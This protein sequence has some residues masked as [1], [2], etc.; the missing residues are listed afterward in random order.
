MMPVSPAVFRLGPS[1][2]SLNTESEHVACAR[3][4]LTHPGKRKRNIVCEM[5]VGTWA[6]EELTGAAFFLFRY[7]RICI[8]RRDLIILRSFRGETS[9]VRKNRDRRSSTLSRILR[10]AAR[11]PLSDPPSYSNAG[12]ASPLLHAGGNIAGVNG[13]SHAYV[14]TGG[15]PPPLGLKQCP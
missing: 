5:R 10:V 15:P 3:D 2:V 11:P 8:Q 7:R 6:Q 13:S 9:C 12:G 4:T 14:R 1:L